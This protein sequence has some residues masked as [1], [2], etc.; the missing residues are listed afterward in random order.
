MKHIILPILSLF[1]ALNVHA[2]LHND[3]KIQALKVSFITERLALTQ[4]EA[5]KFWPIYN[6]Y[7]K[8][9]REIKH[10]DIRNIRR[11]IRK[12]LESIDDKRAKELLD[13]L[14][15]YEKQL[16]NEELDLNKKLQGIISSKKIILL[17]V[18]E[19]DFK[20][21]LFEQF[22]KMRHER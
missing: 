12:N 6:A 9:I 19:E 20:R 7:N 5:Q 17:K 18:A 14:S 1:F 21:K 16:Y 11:E 4:N 13:A 3:D 10:R 2:Q 8:T 15:K 22:K